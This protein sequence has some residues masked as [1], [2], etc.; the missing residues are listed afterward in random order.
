MPQIFHVDISNKINVIGV[1]LVI[2]AI[3]IFLGITTAE[4]YYPY[5]YS[6]RTDEI[7]DLA[8]TKPPNSIITQ[9]S[10]T[11]FNS[12]MI[13]SGVLII[14]GS[15]LFQLFYKKYFVTFP[16]GILGMGYLGVGLFPGNI[17]PWHSIFA[18]IIFIS[19]GITP[20][21]TSKI[22]RFPFNYVFMT[23]GVTTLFFLV[24]NQYFVSYLG[25]GGAERFIFYPI[26]F[27]LF[28]FGSYL[29]GVNKKE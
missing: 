16:L 24:F 2:A 5:E 27:W 29:I 1:L 22:T 20:I 26:L 8:A 9:P 6:I 11:I 13:F 14:A 7:S 18:F 25:K 19:G 3:I 28:C 15:I 21:I 10:A 4:I 23:L 17:T 12:A